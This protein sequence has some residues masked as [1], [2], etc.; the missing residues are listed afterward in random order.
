MSKKTKFLVLRT[1]IIVLFAILAGR[2]WYV[3]VVMSNYY[4]AQADTSKIRILPVAAPR[5]IIYDRDGL[6]LVYNTPSWQI[7]VV[8]HGIPTGQA[9]RIYSKL[10]VLLH[11]KPGPRQ[12][13]YTVWRARFR[14]YTPVLVKDHVDQETALAVKQFHSELPGVRAEPVSVRSYSQEP[15]T[16]PGYSLSH[17]L[18]YTGV[19]DP[20]AYALA[21]RQ[22]PRE[23]VD[24]TDQAG[25]AGMELA[26]DPYLHGVN[27]RAQVEVDAGERPIRVLRNAS[28]VPGDS[29]YLTID[30]KL[31]QQVAA[32]LA[33]GLQHLGL[34]RG[35][36]V[37]EDVHTGQIL[38]MVSLPSFNNN[39]FAGGISK[40]QYD[41]LNRQRA[42]NDL[43]TQGEFP[44]GSTY[45]VVSAAAALET[46]V[47]DA[48]RTIDDTGEIKPCPTCQVFHGWQ[49]PPG[50]GPMNVVSALARS[51]DIYFYTV[52]GGNPSVGAMPRVGGQRLAYW[53]HQF[54]LGDTT[55]IELPNESPGFI[56]TPSWFNHYKPDRVI[57]NPGDTWTIGYDYNS[58]IGQ[59]FDLATPLQMVNATAA[60]ANGG[61]VY[62]P[63][64]VKDIR[65][66]VEPRKGALAGSQVIQPFV[67][68]VIRRGIVS[69]AD[70]SLIQ[71]G[72]HMSV[73][74]LPIGT[75]WQ[76]VD[77]RIDAAGKTGTAED[78]TRPPHAWWIGYAPYNHPRVAIAVLV[79]NAGGEGAYVAAPI[80]HKL[81]EDY[82]HLP[83][84]KGEWLSNPEFCTCLVGSG[85]GAQ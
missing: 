54:G 13:A 58:A 9:T 23:Q 57:K 37:L 21:A 35:V 3:Q 42:F 30:W 59:G 20:A 46:G 65:G 32:D 18:G 19:I 50:L 47:A 78:G 31:Q 15:G 33:A 64:L 60:I 53:A 82:F 17:I 48:S 63:R 61:T 72:M 81:L 8:P 4:T 67:P 34:S 84:Q 7:E 73:T 56:P 68:S 55:G 51:S 62:Q 66:R 41:A 11:G 28:T 36:A 71:Q 75:S 74:P 49:P 79:P 77:G 69:P 44:P 80:A 43:A 52:I 25:R 76:V 6:A 5:G 29:V 40:R 83:V 39:L 27:G 2:L 10:A 85:G 26:L 24:P 12:I 70:L 1:S 45:K 16:N 22:Y 14:P 38:S